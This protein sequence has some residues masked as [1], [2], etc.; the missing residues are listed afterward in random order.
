VGDD[1][2]FTLI[3]IGRVCRGRPRGASDDCWE[4]AESELEIDFA[5]VDALDGIEE[6][7]HLWVLWWLDA[8]ARPPQALHVHPERRQD[9]PLVGL[10]ATR[11]PV[12]PNPVA[13]TAVRLLRREGARL[14]V[15]G[16]DAFEGSPVLD[17]KPYLRRGDQILE[18]NQPGW[19]DRL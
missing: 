2:N 6:F 1:A 7:S 17:L 10:F 11:S 3:P 5:W 16:L 4:E 14:W 18:V 15:S 13:M 8:V 12:R 9:L 19:L